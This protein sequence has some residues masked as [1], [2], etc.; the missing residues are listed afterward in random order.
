MSTPQIPTDQIKAD[1]NI[2][3]A[4][5]RQTNASRWLSQQDPKILLFVA[6]GFGWYLGQKNRRPKVKPLGT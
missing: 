5:A 3:A 6:I 2:L 4:A 1:A